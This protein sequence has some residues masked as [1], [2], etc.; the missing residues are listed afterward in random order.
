MPSTFLGLNTALSGLTYYQAAINTTGHNITNADTDGY[1]RQEV[2]CRASNA[3]R[4]RNTSGMMGTGVTVTGI[5][6]IRDLFYD[7]KYRDNAAKYGEYN[8]KHEYLLQLESYVNEMVSEDGMTA[9]LTSVN[10]SIQ[11]L[12]GNAGDAT[13]RTNYLNCMGTYTDFINEIAENFKSV[14]KDANDEIGIYVENINSIAKQIYSLNKQ[15]QNIE[16]RGGSANDLRDQR[17]NL[18]DELSEI[19]N[20]TVVE[21]PITYGVGKDAVDSGATNYTV[22]INGHLLVDNMEYKQLTVVARQEK[23]NETDEDG[24]YDVHWLGM[25]GSIGDKLSLNSASMTG[26]LKGLFE[27]RDGNNAEGFSGTIT[28]AAGNQVTVTLEN[29]VDINKFNIPSEGTITLNGKDYY[30]EG[31]DA[32]Y[33]DQGLL[34]EF[35]FK[36]LETLDSDRNRVTASLSTTLLGEAGAI[37]EN[38]D[39]QGVPYYM[40]QLNEFVRTFSKYMNDIV[41][42]G[43]DADGEAG[44]DM[45]TALDPYGND[46]VLKGSSYDETLGAGQTLS[47]GDASYYRLTA[48]NWSVNSAIAHDYNKVVVSY[49]EDIAQGNVAAN[50]L[51]SDVLFG[52][53]DDSMFKQGTPSQ[54]MESVVSSIAVD[55]LKMEMFTENQDDIV[56]VIDNQRKSVSSVEVNEEASNLVIYQHGYDLSCKVMSVINEI[57]DKLINEMG[58]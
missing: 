33:D 10:N 5:T 30:Y 45:F 56:N 13:C 44:L 51:L 47:S 15:I 21:T 22:R 57:L 40:A 19:I 49:A 17:A 8:T 12:M 38:V 16:T 14:Q 53:S 48:F 2:L 46:F 43:V 31:W 25:D 37:G 41:T 36:N 42:Q 54:F 1:S 9:I 26:K 23:V 32:V 4:V 39:Y 29:G 3:L 20:V 6:Q 58:Y 55:A 18:V 34:K 11:S 52:F 24:L 35:T 50:N 7:G 28:S 27:T